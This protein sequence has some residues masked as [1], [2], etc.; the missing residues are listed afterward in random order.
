MPKTQADWNEHFKK[1]R[2]DR[3]Q[4]AIYSYLAH[5]TFLDKLT[6]EEV[7]KEIAQ[8]VT[9]AMAPAMSQIA[10][11]IGEE[12][13][14]GYISPMDWPM[15]PMS[16][17]EMGLI[18]DMLGDSLGDV[19]PGDFNTAAELIERIRRTQASALEI[20]HKRGRFLKDEDGQETI[21]GRDAHS[22]EGQD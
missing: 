4:S 3:I 20:E 18:T 7:G 17:Y 13:E 14:G 6:I 21:P 1:E 19:D 2:A 22:S 12:K 15:P 11:I 8:V 10:K 5:L 9:R 16:T